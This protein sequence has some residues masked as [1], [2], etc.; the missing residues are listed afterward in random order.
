MTQYTDEFGYPISIASMAALNC[1]NAT[2]RGFLS[3]GAETPHHLSAVFDADPNCVRAYVAKGFFCQLLGRREMRDAATD[4]HAKAL[5]KA[6][7]VGVDAYDR[8][9]L[10]ALSDL[11]NGHGSVAADRLDAM[12]PTRPADAFLVKLIHAIRF[13][14]GDN[15]GMRASIEGVIEAFKDDAPASGFIHGCHAFALEET[16]DFEAA[17][18]AG[19]KAL[20]MEP[21]DAWGLHAVA[22]VHDMCGTSL[23]GIRWLEGR[24]A[25]WRHCNN[26]SYHV[27]WHLALFYLDRGDHDAVLNLYDTE[28]RPVHTDDY[29]DISNAA[30]LLWRLQLEGCDVGTRWEE[31]AVIAENRVDDQ[32][33]AF[34]DL[35]Y[36]LALLGGSK[37]D[38]ATQL[39]HSMRQTAAGSINDLGHVDRSVGVPMAYGLT[40][41][42]AGDYGTASAVMAKSMHQLQKVGGSHAQR[43]VFERIA[44]EACLRSGADLEMESLLDHRA[45]R[46]GGT[47][48]YAHS[49]RSALNT[50]RNAQPLHLAP[51]G[52]AF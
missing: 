50:L 45:A 32:C 38:A 52:A 21:N 11:I 9:L 28:V 40:A 1:W 18:R 23:D 20:D 4:A 12:L 13:V 29:R 2:V 51:V 39:L 6:D 8:T 46:R 35:H 42:A 15:Q 43:D 16:G 5:E 37:T 49:K 3:H 41:F 7:L 36:M 27:W 31:M 24:E 22:H 34:A 26:F 17:E 19:R 48:A 47:D 33:L 14:M 30:S 44:I 25:A 10:R